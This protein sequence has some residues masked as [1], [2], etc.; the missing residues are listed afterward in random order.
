MTV[1]ARVRH[2]VMT[3]L[4]KH[5][6]VFADRTTRYV[7]RTPDASEQPHQQGLQ[8]A[9]ASGGWWYRCADRVARL[10]VRE[11]QQARVFGV[12]KAVLRQLE[13]REGVSHTSPPYARR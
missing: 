5:M 9:R 10:G 3:G 8:A 13:G 6:S 7:V 11:G 12:D 2:F 4:D 1:V